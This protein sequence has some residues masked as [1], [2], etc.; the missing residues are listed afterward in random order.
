MKVDS[1]AAK[2]PS[3]ADGATPIRE[4]GNDVLARGTAYPS[5]PGQLQIQN[6]VLMHNHCMEIVGF[7][8]LFMCD[9]MLLVDD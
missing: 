4:L 7:L 1:A 9:L 3:T 5:M 2:E 8:G 6:K